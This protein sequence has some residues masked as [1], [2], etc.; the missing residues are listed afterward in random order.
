VE[1]KYND[2]K[3]QLQKLAEELYKKWTDIVALREANNYRSTNVLL[4][5]Y[6]DPNTGEFT[7]FNLLSETVPGKK[8]D[9]SS[10]SG[11]ENTRRKDASNTKFYL[12]LLINGKRVSH[13]QKYFMN[14]PNFEVEICEAF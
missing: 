10:L 1:R 2:E 7:N 4:K 11:S 5:V 8:N 13:T 3:S 14:W 9:N 12:R 6:T